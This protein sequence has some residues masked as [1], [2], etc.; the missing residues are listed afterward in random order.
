MP[1]PKKTHGPYYG[2]MGLLRCLLCGTNLISFKLFCDVIFSLMGK[3][4]YTQ[5]INYKK[6][7]CCK[8]TWWWSG[9]AYI[10]VDVQFQSKTFTSRLV[11]CMN[12][13]NSLSA[14]DGHDRQLKN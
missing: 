11:E 14:I 10:M 2:P 3:I 13:F 8:V 6:H 1:T 12:S 9:T 5:Y 7:K 4:C